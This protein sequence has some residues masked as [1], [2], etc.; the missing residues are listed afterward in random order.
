MSFMVILSVGLVRKEV[1]AR[2]TSFLFV[3]HK[4]FT[5][6]RKSL[7][8]VPSMGGSIGNNCTHAKGVKAR[9]GNLGTVQLE[10]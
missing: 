2:P 3:S 7:P 1:G 8:E 4:D 9:P 6:A 10:T 5:M